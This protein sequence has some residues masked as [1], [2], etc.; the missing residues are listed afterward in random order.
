MS[1]ETVAE[2]TRSD[3]LSAAD[4][5]FGDAADRPAAATIEEE[6]SNQEA[7]RVGE[8]PDDTVEQAAAD[9]TAAP[10]DLK[11]VVSIRGVRATIGVQRPSADPHIE[12]FDG[13]DLSELARELP[14]V[15][16]RA[17][18]RWEDEPRHPS[19]ERPA[20]PARR[21]NR[22]QQEPAPAS[23]AEEGTGDQPQPQ[24]ETLRLF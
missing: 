9:E 16:E 8:S 11:V 6:D 23:D 18:S 1:D 5:L 17:E 15:A 10:E 24:S 19:H 3:G 21:R 4:V 12:S 20:P 7:D 22:R 14:A 2:T 13:L